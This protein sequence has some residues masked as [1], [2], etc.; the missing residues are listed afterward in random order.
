MVGSGVGVKN[1]DDHLPAYRVREVPAVGRSGEDAP[2]HAP[3]APRWLAS[4]EGIL[5]WREI[6][7]SPKRVSYAYSPYVLEGVFR[8][9]LA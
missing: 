7:V 9:L 5:G 4:N 1:L 3:H 8:E 2:V 6:G